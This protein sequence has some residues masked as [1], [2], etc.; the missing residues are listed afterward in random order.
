M[1][2]KGH[3]L[4]ILISGIITIVLLGLCSKFVKDQGKKDK[5]L[6]LAAILT[7]IIHYSVLYVDYFSTGTAEVENT[8]LLPIYPCNVAMWLLLIVAFMKNRRGKLYTVLSE[9]TF[10][11][12]IVGGVIGIVFNEIYIGNP[13][14]ADYDVLNGL[15]SHSTLLFGSI[16]LLVGNYINIRVTNVNSVFCGLMLLLIDG[17]SIITLYRIFG[18]E[19]PN[20]MYLLENPF[21]QFKWFNT[22]VLGALGLALVFVITCIYEQIALPESNRW[23]T[24][25]KESKERRI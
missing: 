15:L 23:Y 10:Y 17:I 7:V 5:I 25:L 6:K 9:F 19:S 18:M 13:N 20:C 21:P 1:F 22:F 16:Y 8:M 24:K 4:Y 12:G 14:L 3:V 11:L 2:D